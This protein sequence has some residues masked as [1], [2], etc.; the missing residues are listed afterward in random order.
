MQ[1]QHGTPSVMET[2]KHIKLRFVE[3]KKVLFDQGEPG[4]KFYIIIKGEVAVDIAT[5]VQVDNRKSKK[6]AN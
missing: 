6:N 5:P 3:D 1:K 4:D 2:M